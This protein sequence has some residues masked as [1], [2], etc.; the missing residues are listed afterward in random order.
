MSVYVSPTCVTFLEFFEW[1]SEDCVVSGPKH[2]GKVWLLIEILSNWGKMSFCSYLLTSHLSIVV[3]VP[4][5]HKLFRQKSSDVSN[6]MGEP[7]HTQI[8]NQLRLGRQLPTD[9]MRVLGGGGGSGTT[10]SLEVCIG[11]NRVIF[12][13]FG[14]LAPT[15]SFSLYPQSTNHS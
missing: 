4:V 9:S 13:H 14:R 8:S 2:V 10:W 3:L 1:H 5:C 7:L 15:T 11:H 12:P 6:C